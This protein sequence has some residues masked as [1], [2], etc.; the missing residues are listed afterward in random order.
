MIVADF[1]CI[2]EKSATIMEV[3]ARTREAAPTKR[4]R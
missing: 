4:T 3:E 2:S 1:S